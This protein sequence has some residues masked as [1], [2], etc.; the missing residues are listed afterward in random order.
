LIANSKADIAMR[1]LNQHRARQIFNIRVVSLP[2]QKSKT[3]Y[4]SYSSY[5]SFILGSCLAVS[6]ILPL[7]TD[8]FHGITQGLTHGIKMLY[9]VNK[10][11]KNNF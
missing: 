1:F 7:T 5:A 2:K 4:K 3:E 9:N 11:Y 10:E 8:S 6:E